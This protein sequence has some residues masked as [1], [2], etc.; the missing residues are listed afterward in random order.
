MTTTSLEPV[1]TPAPVARFVPRAV[2]DSRYV[3]T[4]LPLAAG[5]LLVPVTALVIGAGLAV[6]GVGLPLMMFALMQA[7]GFAA[8]ERER[9]AAVLGREIHTP[10]YRAGDSSTLPGRL[11]SVLL[12]R[13]TWRDLAHAASR[14]IPSTVA[15]TVVATWWAAVLGGF[16]WALWG[17]ARPAE[18]TGLPRMIGLGDSYPVDV[19]FHAALAL[20]FLMTLPPVARWAARFEARFARR[21]LT[22]AAPVR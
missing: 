4:G 6:L 8:T 15:F 1:L 2:T 18:G 22:G 10:L 7:R 9:V 19:A 16:S 14:W 5:A 12:D 20:V 17:W 11:L 3:L 21:L 13:Q